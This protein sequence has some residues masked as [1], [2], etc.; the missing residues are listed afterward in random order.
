VFNAADPLSGSHNSFLDL[1]YRI[2][3]PGL[4][5]FLAAPIALFVRARA[6]VRRALRSE[7]SA[8]LVTTCTC[9]FAFLAYSSFNQVFD[10]PHMSIFFWILLGLGA[11]L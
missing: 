6:T 8:L 5:L 10:T 1:T 4:A 11:P 9:M 3:I 2:G 7:E